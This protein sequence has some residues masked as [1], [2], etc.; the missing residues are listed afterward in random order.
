MTR[1]FSKPR[2]GGAAAAA[3]ADARLR[4]G[5]RIAAATVLSAVLAFG[6]AACGGSSSGSGGDGSGGTISIVGYSTPQELYEEDAQPAFNAT[7]AGKDVAFKDSFGASGDQSR[8]VEAGLPA[9][10]MHFALAPDM[11]REV[12]AGLVDSNWDSGK[13]NG[14]VENSVVV[15]AVRAGNPKNI[16][17]WDDL[18]GDVQVVTP[19]PFTSGGARWNIMAAY[20]SQIDQGKTP[21]E[22]LDFVS[23]VL[24]KTVVQDASARDALQTFTSG[25]GDVLLTYEN[26]AIQ[27]QAAGEDIE[28]VIPDQTILIQTPFAISNNPESPEATQAFYDYMF[29]TAGQTLFAE[30]GFRPVDPAV[31]AKYKDKFPEPKDLF[32][33]DDLGGWDKVSTDFFD[34]TNG[35]VAAI[36]ANLGVATE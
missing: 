13:Y 34:T 19:N 26:D 30:K 21:Q 4:G 35:S 1:F 16:Q 36:E 7:P 11:Q 2:R 10:I 18:N 12:D 17:G 3:D 24:S 33:I 9:D 8:A 22:A 6:V 20:G 27:A 32:T 29:S 15:M 31:A 5:A 14:I 25:Q 23:N 28:Y